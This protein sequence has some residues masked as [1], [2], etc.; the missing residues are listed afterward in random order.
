MKFRDPFPPPNGGGLVSDPG[1]GAHAKTRRSEGRRKTRANLPRPRGIC[2]HPPTPGRLL[3]PTDTGAFGATHRLRTPDSGGN[4]ATHQHRG[5][6]CHHAARSHL[7]RRRSINACRRYARTKAGAS[8]PEKRKNRLRPEGTPGNLALWDKRVP[9]D[10]VILCS[11]GGTAPRPSRRD[12]NG[13]RLRRPF[14]TR[15]RGAFSRVPGLEAPGFGRRPLQGHPGDLRWTA[16]SGLLSGSPPH[17]GRCPS[18][19]WVALQGQ[20]GRRPTLDDVPTDG[21]GCPLQGKH[22]GVGRTREGAMDWTAPGCPRD[23]DS[24]SA[25]DG[26]WT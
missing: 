25:G 22:G 16:P 5:D 24:P 7:G 20:A 12:P 1:Q 3:P 8:A 21:V 15:S 4:G 19:G 9:P 14:R 13:G 26:S 18:A 11:G 2:C 23:Q 6:W 17:G 10:P